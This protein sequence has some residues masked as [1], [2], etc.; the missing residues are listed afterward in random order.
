MLGACTVMGLFVTFPYIAVLPETARVLIPA[1]LGTIAI[2]VTRRRLQPG[3]RAR[4]GA[5]RTRCPPFERW[6]QCTSLEPGEPTIG[7]SAGEDRPARRDYRYEGLLIGGLPLGTLGF[8][9]GHGFTRDR[10]TVPGADCRSG[11]LGDGLTLGLVGAAVGGGLAYVIGRLSS[12]PPPR[13]SVD[14]MGP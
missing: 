9:L 13:D 2:L 5:A 6:D 11:G 4:G 3:A 12:K 1:A 10:P 7:G 8:I 14:T